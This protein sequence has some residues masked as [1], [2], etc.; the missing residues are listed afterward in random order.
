MCVRLQ[1][2]VINTFSW[3]IY[4]V[5]KYVKEENK[6]CSQDNQFQSVINIKILDIEMYNFS[7]FMPDYLIM[8]KCPKHFFISILSLLEIP[9]YQIE[10]QL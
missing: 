7:N 5:R 1:S 10:Q 2:S 9:S 3:C 8:S 6:N 4:N